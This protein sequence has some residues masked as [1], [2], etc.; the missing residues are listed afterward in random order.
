VRARPLRPEIPGWEQYSE[1][2]A[3]HY[4]EKKIA[5]QQLRA[6]LKQE[7]RDLDDRQCTRRAEVF[8]GDF[9][10]RGHLLNALRAALSQEQRVEAQAQRH[11][12][13]DARERLRAQY[14]PFPSIERWLREQGQTALAEQW[15]YRE[16][17]AQLLNGPAPVP[18]QQG[19]SKYARYATDWKTQQDSRRDA[20]KRVWSQYGRDVD[21]LKSA[22][23][24][25][26]AFV[27]MV[28]KGQ[29]AGKLWALNARMADQSAWR[30]LHERHRAALAAADERHP[31]LE[32]RTWLG[33]SAKAD[34]QA[35][36]TS[37]RVV[38]RTEAPSHGITGG[39]SRAAR[40]PEHPPTRQRK[41]RSR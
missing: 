3:R 32:W 36:A 22:S 23:K 21:Q 27:R 41:G 40:F 28:T 25:R 26:W 33:K 10:G 34:E 8:S 16:V 1:Q 38:S 31:P 30:R 20:L 7:R 19:A 15:R 12:H 14:A 35:S 4:A 17:T 11:E 5:W 37:A 18:E 39:V 9:A 13:A 24:R 29:I 2:R 6:R